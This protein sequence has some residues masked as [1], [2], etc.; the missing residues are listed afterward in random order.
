MHILR[1]APALLALG[2]AV[3]PAA[4]AD[5]TAIEGAIDREPVYQEQPRYCLL[6]FGPEARTRMWLVLDKGGGYL[7]R[8]GNGDLTDAG[9]RFTTPS[10]DLGAVPDADGTMRPS[11]LHIEQYRGNVRLE[12]ALGTGC[13][14]YIGWDA[15]DPLGLAGR[16]ADAPIVHVGGPL[17]WI[18]YGKAPT[19]LP[20]A[21]CRFF[22]RLG[23][24]GLGK[25]TF[26]ALSCCSVPDKV[27]LVAQI[28]FPGKEVGRRV[29]AEY[30]LGGD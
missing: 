24:P 29:L 1:L 27:K 14:H 28:D 18:W 21:R 5:L 23:T 15:Q 8:N 12:I 6:V 3:A 16:A 25:G 7:D 26:A 13:L 4:A 20:G 10:V 17:T 11:R 19:L 22:T 9:E 30:D 2:V